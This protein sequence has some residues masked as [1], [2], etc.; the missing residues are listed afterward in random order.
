[1]LDSCQHV[2]YSLFFAELLKGMIGIS[3]E[4][5]GICKELADMIGNYLQDLGNMFVGI[6]CLLKQL[7]G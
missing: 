4:I 7:D 1:M 2:V 6:I 3:L 5:P